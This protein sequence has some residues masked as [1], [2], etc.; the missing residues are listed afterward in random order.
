[1]KRKT[2]AQKINFSIIMAIILLISNIQLASAEYSD[3][4]TF[5]NDYL[6]Q[7]VEVRDD[8]GNYDIEEA[9]LMIDRVGVIPEILLQEVANTGMS[10]ILMDFPL[11][12]L[13]EY[14][15]LSGVVPRGWE[16]TGLTWDD[17]PGAGGFDAAA[18]IG[19]SDPGNGHSTINLELHEFSHSLDNLVSAETISQTDEFIALQEEEQHSMFGDRTYYDYTEEYF[20]ETMAYYYLGGDTRAELLEKAPKTHDFI[21]SL[22]TRILS[23]DNRTNTSVDLS[24]EPV[25][26]ATEY[27]IYRNNIL[28]DTVT[29]TNYQDS[30]IEKLSFYYYTVEALDSTGSVVS[31]TYETLVDDMGPDT[32]PSFN[33]T[34][35]NYNTVTLSWGAVEEATNYILTRDGEEI[36]RTEELSYTDSDLD[37]DTM[38]EYTVRVINDLDEESGSYWLSIETGNASEEPEVELPEDPENLESNL[39]HYNTVT[40]S[41]D[42]VEN[43]DSYI[44]LRN[45]EEIDTTSELTYIDSDLNENTNYVYTIQ[46]V[47]DDGASGGVTTEITTGT[48]PDEVEEPEAPENLEA[49]LDHYN[50]VTLS[51]DAVENAGFYT[52]LRNGEEIHTTSELGYTDSDLNEETN[53]IYT[54]QAFNEIGASEEVTIEITT[55]TAPDEPEVELPEDPENLEQNLEDYNTITLSWNAVDNADFYT[56]LR[57]GEVIDTT[58]ELTYSDSGLNENTNYTYTIHA[59][60]E[61]GV[62]EGVMIEVTTGTAPDPD[63]PEVEEPVNV[64]NLKANLDNFH[65]VTLSWDAVEN[66]DSYTIVRDGETIGTTNDLTYTDS[67]LAEETAYTYTI[68]AINATGASEGSVVEITTGSASVERDEPEEESVEEDSDFEGIIDGDDEQGQLPSTATNIYTSLFIGAML[69]IFGGLLLFIYRRKQLSIE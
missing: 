59:T 18:R 47:N 43:A 29:S 21:Q 65:T 27:Q 13:P 54:I 63:E 31:S 9:Q 52:I 69:T 64:E 11:T 44:I 50:T 45:G 67:E 60:N 34:L 6:K 66:A 4:H 38:Y 7:I 57:D 51:W 8:D 24:W 2:F 41:W 17:V 53:Y 10:L 12:D 25:P 58:T 19:Y 42:A 26:S 33:A 56:I 68:L 49:D 20:A 15:Y 30:P 28:I 48:A 1:M 61:A 46:A 35:D 32:P 5:T 3:N 55:G 40:L 62:S 37:E 22:P 36:A 23:V 39:H 16:H 14:A